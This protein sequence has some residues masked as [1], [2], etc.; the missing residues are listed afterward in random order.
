MWSV[1]PWQ[2]ALAVALDLVLGDPLGWPHLTRGFGFLISIFEKQ[3]AKSCG[4]TVLAGALLWLVVCWGGLGILAILHHYSWGLGRWLLEVFVIY[5]CIAAMD[6]QRHAVRVLRP[7]REKRLEEAR[8]EL[9]AIVGRDTAHL[10][11]SEISRATIESVA[12]SACDAFVA[13]LFWTVFLGAPGALIY[14]ATNTLDSMVGHRTP[15]HEKIGK[16]SARAD[17]VLSF[18]PARLVALMSALVFG[19]SR[20][21]QIAADAVKHKSPNAGWGE[22]ACAYALNLRLGGDNTYGGELH[23]GEVFHASAPKPL[24]DDITR[25]LRW[26]WAITIFSTLLFC[27]IKIWL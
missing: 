24:A 20:W 8:Q 4:R 18:V 19:I 25:C 23:R 12:E 6:L 22:A 3:L 7:L 5:Q 11:E 26:H 10:D 16:W 1:D 21:N 17:D 13:P 14:R 2:I 27:S 9:S 15:E